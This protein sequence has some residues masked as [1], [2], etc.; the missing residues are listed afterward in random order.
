MQTEDDIKANA[1][2]LLNRSQ[3]F[4]TCLVVAPVVKEILSNPQ[5]TQAE[6]DCAI[7]DAVEAVAHI[8]DYAAGIDNVSI[9]FIN[10]IVAHYDILKEYIPND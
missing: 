7:P 10:H 2:M 1:V 9:A 8:Y 6:K 5:Y 3:I 4:K